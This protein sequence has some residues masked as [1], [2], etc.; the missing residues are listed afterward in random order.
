MLV[1]TLFAAFATLASRDLTSAADGSYPVPVVRS[2]HFWR[3]SSYSS[4]QAERGE[5]NTNKAKN[6]S[7]RPCDRGD[8]FVVAVRVRRRRHNTILA[9]PLC[10]TGYVIDPSIPEDPIPRKNELP[11]RNELPES[12][13]C[14]CHQ[15]KTDGI[16]PPKG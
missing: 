5:N 10:L 12:L 6:K 13:P 2:F 4:A 14:G 16:L 11:E 15:T 8:P 3:S 9:T 1:Q 7:R